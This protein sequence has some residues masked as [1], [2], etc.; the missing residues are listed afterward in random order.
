[1]G[2]IVSYF[3]DNSCKI[4]K[5][6]IICP[7]FDDGVCVSCRYSTDASLNIGEDHWIFSYRPFY[8]WSS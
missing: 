8:W 2:S 6:E 7:V 3:A 5:K 1:M 4:C